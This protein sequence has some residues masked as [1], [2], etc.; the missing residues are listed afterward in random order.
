[1]K[2][3]S[4]HFADEETEAQAGR[5]RPLVSGGICTRPPV[6]C[7]GGHRVD[8]GA[9][10]MAQKM[11]KLKTL[12]GPPCPQAGRGGWGLTCA[13]TQGP[14][15][16]PL[17]AQKGLLLGLMLCSDQLKDFGA[18]GG[19]SFLCAGLCTRVVC[20]ALRVARPPAGALL[21][22]LLSVSC[23][24]ALITPSQGPVAYLPHPRLSRV[25]GTEQFFSVS[26]ARGSTEQRL[27]EHWLGW[28]SCGGGSEPAPLGSLVELVVQ[29]LIL[30]CPRRSGIPLWLHLT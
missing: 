4:F 30:L 24:P 28:A 22:P 16:P 1:M 29:F 19:T 26:K 11:L 18:R 20:P 6:F 9:M 17:R 21:P 3:Y 15:P 25:L 14:H 23:L 12:P 2:C 27:Q 8:W 7:A 10:G 5:S 13:V